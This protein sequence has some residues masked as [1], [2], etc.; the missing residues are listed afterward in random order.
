MLDFNKICQTRTQRS[1][2]S[3][4]VFQSTLG[5]ARSMSSSSS[6]DYEFSGDSGDDDATS[7]SSDVEE[8][9]TTK[10][11]LTIDDDDDRVV[12][13]GEKSTGKDV[14][15]AQPNKRQKRG[16]LAASV[17]IVFVS[18]LSACDSALLQSRT[19]HPCTS[20]RTVDSTICELDVCEI[21]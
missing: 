11:R 14:K 6:S 19:T 9:P 13:P 12:A 2:A 3:R 17:P 7:G 21:V 5:K 20:L 1:A 4:T 15:A 8:V 18:I 16:Q 10:R